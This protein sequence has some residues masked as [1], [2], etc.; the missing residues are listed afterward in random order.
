M[1]E[2]RLL[3]GRAICVYTGDMRASGLAAGC[4]AGL[5][6]LLAAA[7]AAAGARQE[8][9]KPDVAFD[10]SF[11]TH[12]G[13]GGWQPVAFAER[14]TMADGDLLRFAVRPVTVGTFVYLFV[15][16]AEGGVGLLFPA[17]FAAFT[18]PDYA[19]FRHVV[20]PGADSFV[21][22]GSPAV[23][24]FTLIA[25]S[26]RL[27][28]LEAQVAALREAGAAEVAAAR[29]RVLDEIAALRRQHSQLSVVAEK[30]VTVAVS[31]RE[32]APASEGGSGALIDATEAD[33]IRIEADGF[34]IRTFR[35][36]H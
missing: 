9:G 2:R 26:Q 1:P 28:Q 20:P 30:P 13:T 16:E 24:R 35:V 15:Q 18:V 3:A 27:R 33:W 7:S 25:S 36:E 4:L 23:E 10:W 6:I 22:E 8:I 11:E 32:A 17:D 21:L 31:T 5:S 19:G 34:Y 12:T 14:V 29:Q